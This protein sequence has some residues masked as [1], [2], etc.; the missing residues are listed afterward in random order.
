MITMVMLSGGIDSVYA[1]YRLLRETDDVI[2]V[3]HIHLLTDTGR[4]IAEAQ[5]CHRV[6][7]YCR[8]NVR[9]FS[10][11]ETTIDHRGFPCH[12][13]DLIAA[14]L[15]AGMVASSYLMKTRKGIDRWTVGLAQD[16]EVPSYR[17]RDARNACKANYQGETAPPDLE[18]FPRASVEDQVA[19]LPAEL[20]DLT[21]SCRNPIIVKDKSGDIDKILPCK[22]CKSCLRRASAARAAKESGFQASDV[23]V[24]AHGA[25]PA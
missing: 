18:V 23:T 3:H 2:H 15:E 11:S 6:V 22:E 20:F 1:L 14:G 5:R 13:F 9:D 17:I 4:H 24:A 7:E 16:D 19:Y 25:G 10:Y 8:K 12:G 21:W